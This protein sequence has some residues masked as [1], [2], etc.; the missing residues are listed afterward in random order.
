MWIPV[1]LKPRL[2]GR[3]TNATSVPCSPGLAQTAK[4]AAGL[5]LDGHRIIQ[6]RGDP[7]MIAATISKRWVVGLTVLVIY[8][9]HCWPVF[10][11]HWDWQVIRL[12][13]FFPGLA[14]S[15]LI[16]QS[17][18]RDWMRGPDGAFLFTALLLA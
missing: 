13:P 1:L 12:W 15:A 6:T 8:T 11:A 18:S 10:L 14:I 16:P 2:F 3:R 4:S 7:R 5:D 17:I 9:P